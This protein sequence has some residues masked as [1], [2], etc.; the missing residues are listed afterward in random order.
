MYAMED[1][2]FFLKKLRKRFMK[3]VP[4]WK[5]RTAADDYYRGSGR[6]LSFLPQGIEDDGDGTSCHGRS[7]QQ[8]VD[9]AHHRQR[10]GKGVVTKS[11]SRRH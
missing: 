1:A 3:K 4:G 5:R 9:P 11:C 6:E 10:N 2:G 8:R 7:L